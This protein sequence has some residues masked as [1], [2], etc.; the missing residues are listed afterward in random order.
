LH[1]CIAIE[2]LEKKENLPNKSVFNISFSSDKPFVSQFFST[3]AVNFA[4]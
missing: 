2:N 4:K 1:Y 3:F